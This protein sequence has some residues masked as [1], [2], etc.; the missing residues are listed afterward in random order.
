VQR[1]YCRIEQELDRHPHRMGK[2]RAVGLVG[3]KIEVE[4]GWHMARGR[5]QG[6]RTTRQRRKQCGIHESEA[7]SMGMKACLCDELE[8]Q[9]P[10]ASSGQFRAQ[11]G[12]SEPIC[13]RARSLPGQPERR[14]CQ[15]HDAVVL[16]I[17]PDCRKVQ[18]GLN[19]DLLQTISRPEISR[20]EVRCREDVTDV[21]GF[22]IGQNIRAGFQKKHPSIRSFTQARGQDCSC[23]AAA[24]DDE[25]E[26]HAGYGA[27]EG[28]DWPTVR[29]S[30][31]SRSG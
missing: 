20:V 27:K 22:A 17:R 1:P 2:P 8:V 4:T 15:I 24:D 13:A 3:K 7:I 11:P 19:A 29:M 30:R 14:G 26:F 25:I 12:T 23:R 9:I 16:Q 6:H 28:R 10:R 21:V 18:H 5:V 31:D